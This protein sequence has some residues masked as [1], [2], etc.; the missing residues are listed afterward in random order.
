[1]LLLEII[2]RGYVLDREGLHGVRHWG[3]V[4]EN[5]LRLA[6]VTG[7]DA[8]VVT[9]FALF[10]DARRENDLD[11]PGHGARGAALA[12]SL[13]PTASAGSLLRTI[14]DAEFE[15]LLE[16]CRVHTSARTHADVTVATCV[17]ADR[18]DLPR[19]GIVVDPARLLTDAARDPAVLGWARARSISDHAGEG[20]ETLRAI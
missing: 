8:R 7:A 1:M 11:D 6:V 19:C 2:L 17:D 10:H 5:G 13:R 16:A 20:L 9:L 4:L 3:R 14:P 15:C 18:L 12:R